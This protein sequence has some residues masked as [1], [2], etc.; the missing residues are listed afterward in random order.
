MPV[1]V[2]SVESWYL[3]G[4]KRSTAESVSFEMVSCAREWLEVIQVIAVRI[5]EA[6]VGGV[7]VPLSPDGL[8]D[9]RVND[10][11]QDCMAQLVL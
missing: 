5:D 8:D 3:M 9:C 6:V 1:V 2:D 11:G 10:V 4:V 7:E